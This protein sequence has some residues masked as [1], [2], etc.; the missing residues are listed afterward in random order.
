MV[1]M[2]TLPPRSL[3]PYVLKADEMKPRDVFSSLRKIGESVKSRA[4]RAGLLYK[5]SEE[6]T[7]LERIE[8]VKLSGY[9]TSVDYTPPADSLIA[10]D[11]VSM[12]WPSA[13]EGP[14]NHK[15]ADSMSDYLNT[16]LHHFHI[17]YVDDRTVGW[18]QTLIASPS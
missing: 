3:W 13:V 11:S 7:H 17:V 4:L 12:Y 16:Y 14:I 15:R 9:Y 18:M 1:R 8:T 5:E 6:S 2:W 10:H